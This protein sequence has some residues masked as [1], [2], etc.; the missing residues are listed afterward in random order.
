MAGAAH[1]DTPRQEFTTALQK[2]QAAGIHDYSF[3]LNQSCFCFGVQPVRITVKNDTVQSARNVE[4]GAPVA[5]QVFAK[6]PSM[7]GVF[8]KIAEGYTKPADHIKLTLNQNYGFPEH[9]YIDYV[10]MIA[11]E[12]LIYTITEFTH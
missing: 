11:D 12:E 10:A 3:T 8:Q 5:A 4:D 6:L 1:A 2:W 7:D 9:V